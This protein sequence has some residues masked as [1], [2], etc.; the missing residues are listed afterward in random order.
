MT[1]ISETP[2]RVSGV[3]GQAVPNVEREAK[4][5]GSSIY[6]GDVELPGLLHARILRSTHPHARIRNIDLSRLAGMPGVIGVVTAQDLP[7]RMYIHHGGPLSDRGVLASDVVRFVGEE[8]V[9]VAAETPAAADQALSCIVVD[10]EV[11]PSA[12]SVSEALGPEAPLIHSGGNVPVRHARRWG[13]VPAEQEAAVTVSGTYLFGRQTHACM[14]T[15]TVTASW[16]SATGMLDVWIS[17]Q[18]PYLVRKEL[19]HVLD[20]DVHHIRVHEV[21]VGG[22]FGSKSKISEYEA[23][24]CALSMKTG[25]PVRLALTREEEFTTAKC[26]HSFEINLE[27]SATA[28][29][30]LVRRDAS[31]TVDNGAY[32]HS[33]PSVMAYA[34]QVLGSLYRIPAVNVDAELV[35]TN[36]QPGGQFRGYGGPQAIFALESQM[37]EVADQLGI[38][39]VDLRIL[40]ANLAGDTTL[41]GWRID[42]ARLVECLETARS[43]IGWQGRGAKAPEGRGIGFAASIHV[44]G[45]NI[46]EG[47]DKSSATVEV[48]TDGRVLL[49]FGAA[50]AG[51][52]QNTVVAQFVAHELGIEPDDVQLITMETDATPTELGSWSSRGTY[53]SG[54]SVGQ[55]ARDVAEELRLHGAAMLESPVDEVWLHAGVVT[56][57]VTSVGFGVVVQERLG[58]SLVRTR[59]ITLTNVDQVNRETGISNLSGAYSFAVHA[60]EVSVDEGT[61][62]VKVERYVAVHDSGQIVN[63][64]AARSQVIG[65]VAMGIG[66]ALSEELLYE[67]GMSMTRSYIQYPLPRAADLPEIEVIF[68]EGDDP[69]GP[70]GAKAIGEIV[71]IPPGAAIAN[72]VADATG[73]RMRELPLTPDRVLAALH[74]RDRKPKRNYRIG[75]RPSRWQIAVMRA[76]YP[77]GLHQF[78]HKFGTR[79]GRPAQRAELLAVETPVDEAAA[80]A[81]LARPGARVIA[82]GTD[83]L[84]AR[85]QG[86]VQPSVLVDIM[87][88]PTVGRIEQSGSDVAVGAAV[89]LADLAIWSQDQLSVLHEAIT[90]IATEQIRLMATVGG[91]LCQQNRC[92]FLRNDFMCYKRGGVSCPCYAV[93][94]DHRYYHSVIDSHRCQS[95]TPSDLSTVLSA[96]DATVE[97][98]GGDRKRSM[99]VVDFY[100]G[101]GEVRLGRGEYLRSVVIETDKFSGHDYRKLNRGHGDF[102]MISAAVSVATDM[103]GTVTDA[104]VILGAMAPVPYR[105]HDAERLMVG[106]TV[107][108]IDV[109][110]AAEAWCRR[111]HP[112]ERNEWKVQAGAELLQ[113]SIAAALARTQSGGKP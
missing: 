52:W 92:W 27:T 12:V 23:I 69:N 91:N 56:N 14:E 103:N 46:Y 60:V 68:V 31:M 5:S 51:T 57:G 20:L 50:D 77:R 45:A 19:A 67:G 96:L 8:I 71:L 53:M 1:T 83:L 11:L 35:Y 21:A 37:D 111:A 47:A 75:Q 54:H 94:G 107:N 97:I 72:A 88:I 109:A 99:K 7:D 87:T 70:Y 2:R 90:A 6:A 3:V 110:A 34:G 24:A 108:A 59:E 100:T 65:G 81:A 85:R 66:Y 86:L 42:S 101:P 76:W 22:G 13:S 84:P 79:W 15:N 63:P 62:K 4:T 43:A 40:N 64:I 104:R 89:T 95:V 32:N 29:G 82:G 80:S 16:S 17:T 48:D 25:R 58:G 61:G 78:L 112:L 39:R 102:A 10:Y 105:V 36:K 44:S 30:M 49:R 98:S 55:T 74:Q 26:R 73:V 113:R 93:T 28:E 33:G 106:R 18:S 38:D 9:G 41:T